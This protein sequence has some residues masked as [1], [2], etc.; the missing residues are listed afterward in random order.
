MAQGHIYRRSLQDGRPSKWYAVIDQPSPGGRKQITKTF[1]T[2]RDAQLWLAS[3]TVERTEPKGTPLAEWLPRWLSGKAGLKLTSRASYRMHVDR[4]LI[5][6]LGHLEVER[7]TPHDIQAW[8]RALLD[9]GIDP[10]T[11]ARIHAT[12]SSALGTARRQGL[13]Q[14]N[15]LAGVELPRRRPYRRSVW[16]DE[17]ASV[18][19]SGVRGDALE[20]LWRLALLAGLRRGELLGLRWRD[21]DLKRDTLTVDSTRLRLG[22]D[23]VEDGPKTASSHRIVHIDPATV[24]V[25]RRAHGMSQARN[26]RHVFTDRDGNPLDPAAVSRRFHELRER[27]GLPR[28]RLHD[29]RHTSATLGLDS[30]ESLKEVSARLGHS[31]IS[32]T[33]DLYTE[34]T[35]GLARASAHRLAASLDLHRLSGLDEAAA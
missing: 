35:P 7:L 32:V 25:L 34:V 11:I 22:G 6:M 16:T 20:G 29:L 5:P 12:L 27:L 24:R 4:Y 15:P 30:G 2:K 18:F 33:A 10:A 23:I 26:E 8:H 19:L 3:R 31:A 28:I 13:L 21:L 17:E 9:A 14:R 1:A